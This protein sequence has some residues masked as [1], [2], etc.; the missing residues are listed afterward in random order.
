MIKANDKIYYFTMQFQ[1]PPSKFHIAK[2]FVS[3][4][5]LFNARVFQC[6]NKMRIVYLHSF[7]LS[8]SYNFTGIVNVINKNNMA[9]LENKTLQWQYGLVGVSESERA[10]VCVCVS[11]HVSEWHN[12]GAFSRRRYKREATEWNQHWTKR[13]LAR[14]SHAIWNTQAKIQRTGK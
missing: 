14:M 3:L 1:I 6:I 9:V 5:S 7:F 13:I 11:M 4:F 12:V 8:F 10:R 2:H